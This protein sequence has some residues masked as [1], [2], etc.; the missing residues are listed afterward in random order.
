LAGLASPTTQ[1]NLLKVHIVDKLTVRPVYLPLSIVVLPMLH[2][3]SS[4]C[5]VGKK[6]RFEIEQVHRDIYSHQHDNKRTRQAVY[7]ERNMEALSY[8]HCYGGKAISITCCECGCIALRRGHTILTS[9]ELMRCYACSW[10]VSGD[11]T[12]NSMAQI[13]TCHSAYVA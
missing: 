13:H 7:I 4:I 8:N 5:R 12:L 2:T 10:R 3:H 9:R 6:R 11:L 1:Y